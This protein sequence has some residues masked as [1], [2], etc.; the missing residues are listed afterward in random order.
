MY[1]FIIPYF[2]TMYYYLILALQAY[3]FYHCFSSKN[4][5]YWFFVI[6]FLPVIGC[7]VYL[8]M[9]VIRKKDVET[10]QKELTA[11][12]NPTKKIKD[13]ENKLKFSDT[14]ES[15]VALADAYLEN[16]MYP[17]AIVQ[18]KASLINMFQNDFY[19]LSKLQEAY[20]FSSDFKK[21]L[22]YAKRIEDQ[23]KFK[24]SKASFLYALALEKE[25]DV[26]TAEKILKTMQCSV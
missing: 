6:L 8:F 4:P 3:C 22:E 24:K 2:R 26:A 1:A 14:F 11:V 13:L 23:P 16:K 20:Y 21:S 9:N 5:Y 17:E 19:V 12:I 15:K 10:L 18:Y 25:G 7:A